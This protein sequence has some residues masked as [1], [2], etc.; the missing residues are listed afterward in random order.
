MEFERYIEW[1][2]ALRVLRKSQGRRVSVAQISEATELSKNTVDNFF[3]GKNKDV[4]RTTM[5]RIERYLI[6]GNTQSP[7]AMDLSSPQNH[8]QDIA[9]VR[10]EY[11]R[12]I[13]YLL[14]ELEQKNKIINKLLGM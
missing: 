1:L 8:E 6:G 13:D 14:Q 2:R 7:C 10:A 11:Q 5:R 12:K 9:E 3:A 4:S